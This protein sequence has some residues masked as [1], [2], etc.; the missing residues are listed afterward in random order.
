MRIL[1]KFLPTD[2]K[3]RLM[4]P[5]VEQ[6]LLVPDWYEKKTLPALCE[7]NFKV[8][9]LE[10]NEQN[11]R[12]LVHQAGIQKTK[13]IS[14]IGMREHCLKVNG[15]WNNNLAVNVNDIVQIPSQLF[16]GTI[17]DSQ[18]HVTVEGDKV[19]LMK[20]DSML[21]CPRENTPHRDDAE[22][23]AMELDR[24]AHNFNTKLAAKRAEIQKLQAEAQ[25][26]AEQWRRTR[27]CLRDKIIQNQQE[28][29]PHVLLKG[30]LVELD[31]DSQR[32]CET[33][34]STS[35]KLICRLSDVTRSYVVLKDNDDGSM[36][37]RKF[38]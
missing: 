20:V 17:A 32:A 6:E 38:Y 11:L 31:G 33:A 2:E 27:N 13:T 4:N 35:A 26:L 7:G 25:N 5:V 9:G 30:N 18:Q 37:L 22:K 24:E 3:S 34:H 36:V 1:R 14:T 16:D 28:W 21:C 19:V 12:Q 8:K 15:T 10:K 23:R 29:C